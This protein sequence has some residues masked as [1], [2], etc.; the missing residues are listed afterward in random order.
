MLGVT[1]LAACAGP[2]QVYCTTCD[3][4]YDEC[5]VEDDFEACR[6]MQRYCLGWCTG[7][8]SC[9]EG[10]DGVI[11]ACEASPL[12]RSTCVRSIDACRAHCSAEQDL[13]FDFP[14]PEEPPAGD[15][16]SAA[17]RTR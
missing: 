11:W 2:S 13:D 7:A 15:D 1:L 12:R 14:L 3:V 16:G 8:Q 5:R 17:T 4:A 6:L 9:D 10:C